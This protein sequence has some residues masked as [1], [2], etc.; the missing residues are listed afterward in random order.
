MQVHLLFSAKT[1][2]KRRNHISP[3]L[4]EALQMLKFHLKK[5]HPNFTTGWITSKKQMMED[6]LDEDLLC[7]LLEGDYQDTLDHAI[8]SINNNED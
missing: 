1:D 8:Q 4:M 7:K 3:L 2:A 6:N 5:D